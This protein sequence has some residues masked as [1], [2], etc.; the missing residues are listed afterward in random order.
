MKL[1]WLGLVALLG[2]CGGGGGAGTEGSVQ[3]SSP[4]APTYSISG[5]VTTS[6]GAAIS[7]VQVQLAGAA[8]G[9]ATTSAS[10]VFLFVN[11]PDGAYVVVPNAAAGPFIPTGSSVTVSGRSVVDL[12]F[13]TAPPPASMQQISSY[14]SFAYTTAMTRFRAEETALGNRLAAVG[15]YY[16]GA[17]FKG[18][19]ENLFAAVSA[20]TRDGIERLNIT[21][22]TATIDR[23][24]VA[25]LFSAYAAQDAAFADSYY[26]STNFG[27]LTGAALDRFISETV[28]GTNAVYAA[29]IGQ[30]P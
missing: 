16:S 27:G 19:Q 5:V 28:A 14:L 10:G 17:R 4:A 23:V 26:R 6:T 7:G 30:I 20:F 22:K 18:S 13:T 12:A 21:A 9:A 3:P 8:A 2:A 1:L 24:A 15:G 29:A 25:A 11:V